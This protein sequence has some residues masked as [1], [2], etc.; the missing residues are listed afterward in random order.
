[1]GD[2]TT[3]NYSLSESNHK[4]IDLYTAH[5]LRFRQD[6]KNVCDLI[7][8]YPMMQQGWVADTLK[9]RLLQAGFKN[10]N[11]PKF[12]NEPRNCSAQLEYFNDLNPCAQQLINVK[13]LKVTM[14]LNPE[15]SK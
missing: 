6:N 15:Q 7:M 4:R 8:S 3:L 2:M 9:N 1:M 5:F 14:S 10:I 12:W 11:N 13:T